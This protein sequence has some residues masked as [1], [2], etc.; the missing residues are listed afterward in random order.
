MLVLKSFKFNH[1]FHVITK[2]KDMISFLSSMHVLQANLFC[3]SPLSVPT[4]CDIVTCNKK[5][6][7]G[8]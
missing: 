6:I 1:M 3:L 2:T 4:F 7:F 8:L 5:Y